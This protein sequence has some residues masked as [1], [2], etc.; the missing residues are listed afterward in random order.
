MRFKHLPGVLTAVTLAIGCHDVTGP[1]PGITSAGPMFSHS[2]TGAGFYGSG[3]VGSGEATPGSSRQDFTFDI[4]QDLRTGTLTYRDWSFVRGNG[5]TVTVTVS[6]S[7]PNTAIAWFRDRSAACAD[8]TRGAEFEGLGRLDDGNLYAFTVVACDNGPAGSGGDSFRLSI[9]SVGYQREGLVSSGDVVKSGTLPPP[10]NPQVTGQGWIP[11]GRP[12]P[13]PESYGKEF[14]LQATAA[15]SGRL[16]WTDHEWAAPDGSRFGFTANSQID[17]STSVTSYYQLSS[18]CV[19][20]GGTGRIKG[21]PLRSFWVDACDNANPGTGFDTFTL[22]VPLEFTKSGTLTAGDILLG[23]PAP[24]TGDLSVSAATTGQSLDADGYTVTLDGTDPRPIPINGGS[25][26]YASLPA[27][28]H[29]VALSGVATNCTV[30]G[31]NSRTVTVTAGATASAPF[32]VSCDPLPGNLTVTAATGGVSLDQDGYTVTVDGNN[33]RAI[34]I[35]GGSVTYASLPAGN[36]T[37]ALSGVAANCT[38]SGGNS[39][40]VA[41]PAGGTIS[42]GFSI[43][44][45]PGP[46]VRLAFTGQPSNTRV[47]STISPPVQVTAYDAQGSRATG[48]NGPVTIAIGLNGGGLLPGTLSGTRTVNAVNGVA[49]FS[50]LSIDR[51]G[52]YTLRVT[53]SGLTGAESWTFAIQNLVC[54]L[55]VCL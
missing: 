29:T 12:L 23:T 16:Q 20:F 46:A 53:A 15:P 5:S 48:F 18:T 24:T 35:N 8:P 2:G 39:R 34:P 21:G 37:V 6:A 54:V 11:P 44:C 47:N 33:P 27:G 41:V 22:V 28:D 25:V 9:S 1:E 7:D 40:T 45:V 3:S 49:T 17:P 50:N 55:G 26:T 43:T 14:D 13:Y 36:H 4:A 30:S 52:D 31:G 38:V 32:S 10:A 51:A 42:T 19:R